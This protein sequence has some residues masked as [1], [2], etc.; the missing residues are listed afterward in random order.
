MICSIAQLQEKPVIDKT[1]GCKLGFVCDVEIDTKNAVL[2]AIIVVGKRKTSSFFAKNVKFRIEW[3]DI[4]IIGRDTIIIKGGH[5]Y[6][7]VDNSP[8]IFDKLWS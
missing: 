5:N 6:N 1:T 7:N 2:C 8:S 3:N 4:E